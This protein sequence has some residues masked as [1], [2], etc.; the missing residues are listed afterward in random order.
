[1][2]YSSGVEHR[3]DNAGV[4]GSNPS[5]PTNLMR[6]LR[7]MG[8]FL[9]PTQKTWVRFLQGL[10]ITRKEYT[11]LIEIRPGEGGDDAKLFMKDLGKTYQKYLEGKG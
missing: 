9:V 5:T 10:P 11:M 1:M 6:A 4:D 3:A 2:A 8:R 7:L